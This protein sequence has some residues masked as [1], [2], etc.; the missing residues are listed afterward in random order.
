M[1]PP[2]RRRARSSVWLFV[3][4]LVSLAYLLG[5]AV[6]FFHLPTSGFLDK[7][8]TG[9]RAWNER[10]QVTAPT[11]EKDLTP[12][13]TPT[14]PIDRPGKTFDGF[15]LYA[16]ASMEAVST[17]VFAIN[18]DRKVVHTWS[19]SFNDIWPHPTH[20]HGPVQDYLVCIF[21]CHP[22][23][24][25]DLLV[26]FHGMEQLSNG[27]GLAK[28]DKD[29][30]V[31]WKYAANVHHDVDVGPDGTIYA[32]QHELADAMPT[33]LEFIPT[34]C[35]V[36]SLVLL[37]PDGTL[38]KKPIPILEAFRDSPY[39]AL[40]ESLERGPK[41]PEGPG[42]MTGPRFKEAVLM[43]D[44]LHMNSVQVLQPE[45]APKFPAFKAGQVLISLRHLDAIAVLDPDKGSVVWAA[46]GPWRAQHDAQFLDSGRL[47]IFD[48]CG[49]PKGSRV[50]EYD[51]QT[52]AIPWSYSGE[53]R[54]PFYTSERGM[55]Q[56]LPN[57][58][59]LIVSSED[60]ELLE[61]T[62]GKE[63]VWSCHVRAFFNF[64]RRYSAEQLPFLK[65]GP[66]GRP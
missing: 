62:G 1:T 41:R 47:L 49:L 3:L 21:F 35:L 19:V 14:A 18:M 28:L 66:R 43:K 42:V 60:G 12:A 15:T 31:V 13:V 40:L 56:R 51:P 53:H 48:N 8:F 44:A 59:T 29:S 20:L 2:T 38:K 50:L 16:C 55:C 30:K 11:V 32:I 26:V 9:A 6:M 27:Y 10:R 22:F 23:P 4:G 7:A 37:N 46:R 45:L 25:G 65:G 33:G 39:A 61:V 52:Q 54:A 17:K 64:A 63:V 57:G 58:N 24:N 36:D 5:A 34:P